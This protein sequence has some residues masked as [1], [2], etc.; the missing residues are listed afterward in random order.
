MI[1][2]YN[3]NTLVEALHWD[4]TLGTFNR[5]LMWTKFEMRMD[6]NKNLIIQGA[7][8]DI[9]WPLGC[10]IC[11]NKHGNWNLYNDS[12]FHKTFEAVND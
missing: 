2:Y 8:E 5:I 9:I 11:L 6:E 12:Y 1:K 3:R 4:G 7:D 10:W